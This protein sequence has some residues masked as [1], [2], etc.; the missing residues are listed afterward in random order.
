MDNTETEEK[1]NSGSL[2][3]LM[4]VDSTRPEYGV[5]GSSSFSSSLSD[6]NLNLYTRGWFLLLL[7]LLLYSVT[8]LP[9]PL[10]GAWVN[11]WTFSPPPPLSPSLSLLSAFQL[12]VSVRY[13]KRCGGHGS[14]AVYVGLDEL[15]IF[16]INTFL[17][18]SISLQY[19]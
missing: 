15:F 2:V 6:L 5:S 13:R 18:E 10:A 16:L 4:N 14:L 9:M 1:F 3:V 12:F 11:R 7:L 17:N 19:Q 8:F